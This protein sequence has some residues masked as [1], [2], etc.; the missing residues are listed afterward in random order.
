MVRL[1]QTN[2]N[3]TTNSGCQMHL[4]LEVKFDTNHQCGGLQIAVL[5]GCSFE[6]TA[7]MAC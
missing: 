6:E 1:V 4:S 7:Y 2:G 5:I 3:V